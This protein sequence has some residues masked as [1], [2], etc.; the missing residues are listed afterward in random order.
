MLVLRKILEV[1]SLDPAEVAG[2]LVLLL[3]RAED[4]LVVRAPQ[5]GN[6]LV[7]RASLIDQ[8]RKDGKTC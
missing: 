2:R 8:S 3:P 4:A 7:H 6:D 5:R 1:G